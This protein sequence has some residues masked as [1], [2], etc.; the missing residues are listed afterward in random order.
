L[1]LTNPGGGP[2]GYRLKP[3]SSAIGKGTRIK[4]NPAKDYYGNIIKAGPIN[5]GIDQKK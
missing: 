3:G 1:R 4:S 2:A 5:I